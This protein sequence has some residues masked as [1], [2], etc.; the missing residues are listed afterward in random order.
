MKYISIVQ[1]LNNRAKYT[2]QASLTLGPMKVID[3]MHYEKEVNAGRQ[4]E[5][6]IA[7]P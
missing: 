7:S 5:R 3:A 4:K 6:A 1:Q 2:T